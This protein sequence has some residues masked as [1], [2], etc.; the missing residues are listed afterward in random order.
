MSLRFR[1][2]VLSVLIPAF[3]LLG[4]G[5]PANV[6]T[7]SREAAAMATA[8][9]AL[10]PAAPSQATTTTVEATATLAQPSARPTAAEETAGR[11]VLLNVKSGTS[12][13][14]K[15]MWLCSGDMEF[16]SSIGPSQPLDSDATSGIV[17]L[18]GAGSNATVTNFYSGSC[19]SV[20][21]NQ[22]DAG[23]QEAAQAMR[24]NGCGSTC[25]T[26]I[27]QK[28]TA[29]KEPWCTLQ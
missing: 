8:A 3:L 16:A 18:I 14:P 22:A 28:C 26:V 1:R 10:T 15:M 12:L 29:T 9:A 2:T 20:S 17:T 13:D 6:P 25:R 5:P 27:L 11:P 24:R 4:C 19:T 7:N 21:A 23:L